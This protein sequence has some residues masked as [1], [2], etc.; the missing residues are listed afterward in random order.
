MSTPVQT[1]LSDDELRALDEAIEQ[2]RFPSRSEA[3]R[4]G[5]HQV[6]RAEREREIAEAYARGYGSKPQE[7]WVG[8][9][10]LALLDAAVRAEERGA[11]PL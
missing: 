11:E 6:L 9:T 4:A 7:A 8:D 3:L 2:G 10:G 5:L 1:R